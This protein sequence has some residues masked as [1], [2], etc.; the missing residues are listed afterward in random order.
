MKTTIS[1]PVKQQALLDASQWLRMLGR[2]DDIVVARLV[3]KF[4]TDNPAL[5]ERH[6]GAYMTASET[7]KRSQI[8]Y[9]RSYGLGMAIAQVTRGIGYMAKA[10]FRLLRA[11]AKSAV[12][13]QRHYRL[14]ER[15]KASAAISSD[16][17]C[18]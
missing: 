17:D 12:A 13:I 4:L 11:A 5:I 3:L 15:R 14:G 7:V 10:T 9:A 2:L 16:C 18:G 1:D 8:R 6:L